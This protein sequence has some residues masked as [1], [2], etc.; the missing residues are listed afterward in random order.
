M[1]EH[2]E[3]LLAEVEALRSP[4]PDGAGVDLALE[5]EFEPIKNEIER[6][7]SLEGG[8]PDWGL[9]RR[10]AEEL[11]ATR[12]KDLRLACWLAVAGANE[13]GWHGFARGLA[14][15]RA[16]IF[17]L[18]E[19]MFPTRAKARSNIIGWLAERA[20]LIVPEL[21]VRLE[22][23]DDVRAAN[24]LV[25]EIDREMADKLG[26]AFQGIRSLITA[27]KHRIADIPPP[28]P[29][30]MP[31]PPPPPPD[32]APAPVE[33]P[34]A[35]APVATGGVT[36]ST[37]A[38]DAD[39]T[40]RTIAEALV[41]LA[42]A[43][44][45][46]EPARAWAY[47]LHRK[48][49]WMR[50]EHVPATLDDAPDA[51]LREK[52]ANLLAESRWIELVFAAEEATARHPLW[53]DP[54]RF[55]AIGLERLG[56]AFN[57]AREV[58]GR[59][60][61]DFARHHAAR[62]AEA[63]FADETPVASVETAA[64]LEAE[65]KR[66]L[67]ATDADVARDEDRDLAIRFIEARHLVG[68]G[69][70]AEGL[71]LAM[72][73]ARRGSD[74]R[75]RFRSTLDVARLAAEAGAYD[76]ARPLLESLVAQAEAHNLETWEPALAA[77]LYFGLYRCL[78]DDSPERAK[79][80]ENLCRIDPGRA[81]R[82]Q[83]RGRVAPPVRSEPATN[84]NGGSGVLGNAIASIASVFTPE[85]PAA[86]VEAAPPAATANQTSAAA[87]AESEWADDWD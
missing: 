70:H 49:I 79:A 5:P 4:L 40:T 27:T 52:L 37:R 87:P 35:A 43:V 21:P 10:G 71:A 32:E 41:A 48:A 65:S 19:P 61:S 25:T 80:F 14:V 77:K 64:W 7:T 44:A 16:Y 13:R 22:D 57:E 55:A 63:K 81:L 86:V 58:V 54:Q 73:L 12:T 33:A 26:D 46:A 3:K 78:P 2:V 60:A 18:W 39:A 50:V 67:R 69:R 30:K 6:L 51:A 28:P 31:T 82:V 23:G 84:G 20:V 53:L 72:Q 75:E 38:A 74:P 17:E 1:S 29:P 62:L 42:R 85:A 8:T 66:W 47:S 76:V 45:M 15:V 34:K 83:G 59:A 9:V 36:L 56:S 11:L 24:E 68:G